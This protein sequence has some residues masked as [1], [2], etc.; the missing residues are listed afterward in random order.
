MAEL[1][2]E[3]LGG[4]RVAVGARAISE[5]AWRR[6]KPAALLKLLALAPGHRLHRVQIMEMLWPELDPPAAGA[7]LRKA[8]H[9]ARRVLSAEEGASLIASVGELLSLRSQRLW[10]D[11]DAF[12][13]A[14]A[15]ARRTRDA[16][17]YAHAI[18][19]YRDGLLP[20]DPYEEW[21]I[22]PRDEFHL[23]FLAIL[24]ELA[25]LLE[26]RGDLDEATR[27][28][29]RLV[30]AEP[31]REE[32]HAWLIRLHALAGRR[33]E[34]L[35]QYE[36][37]RELW[38]DELGSEPS[39]ETQRLYE[40]VRGRQ[41]FEPELTSDLWE[42]VGDLRVLSGDAAGAAKAFGLAL[43][44]AG[45]SDAA[46]RLQRKS[47]GAWLMQHRPDEAE[48]H[49]EAAEELASDPAERGRLVC[50]RANQ[51]WERGDLASAQRLAE[52]ARDLAQAYGD[53]DDV[54][55]A[56]EALAIVLHF[57]G[58]W[59]QGLQLELER[60]AVDESGSAHLGRVF[61]IH[62]CIGQYHLYGD[63]LA[64]D[65]EK[66]ARRTLA[67][68]EEAGAVHAQA[69]AWCLLGES[70][71]LHAR[72]DEVAGC[73]E[74]SC[75]LH[76]SL[77]TYS[78]ALP[79]QRLGELAVCRGAHDEVDKCLRRA[80]ALAT[81]S[82]MAGHLWGRI[83]A[84]AAFAAVEQGDPEAAA[85]SVRAAAGAAARY[86][87]CPT[88][89]ALLNPIAAETFALLGDGD[90]VR[91][92]SRLCT[93]LTSSTAPPGAQWRILRRGAPLPR[94]A[95]GTREEARWRRSTQPARG[96]QMPAPRTRSSR[97]GLSSRL[98]RAGCR[99]PA[100]CGSR[101]TCATRSGSSA[102][103]RSRTSRRY[104]PGRVRLS[105]ASGWLGCCSTWMSSRRPSLPWS[106]LPLQERPRSQWGR[107]P[108][109]NRRMRFSGAWV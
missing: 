55:A 37:L 7:N 93:S 17:A 49:L 2:I 51:A 56:C 26:A 6:R 34:A 104:G 85:R 88:C 18:D 62:C 68:A 106:P 80:S 21:A 102:S 8:L 40:E 25:A 79:W 64:D 76:A 73:L 31:L 4:F 54:A 39:P 86:G 69:F 87:D 13:A 11:V 78:G 10:V 109:P 24:E 53:P 75:E 63:E 94:T 84:T 101:A 77:G 105:S 81:V 57:R 65:V 72:W 60:L 33:G 70:L 82:P 43:E 12:R 92:P 35:R 58:D 67:L 74:R 29:R 27:I 97:H 66:Y 71:L 30:A 22:E 32:S 44:A 61:D 100:R 28:V 23:E 38:S 52:Q 36:H 16:D 15:A 41:A 83:H 14:V 108:A 3:L 89:S 1:R 5:G 46:V 45:S 50:L 42:R 95:A 107:G 91:T 99:V 19:L 48:P 98:G 96:S 90:G 9:Q 47:A 20:E 59:R 103:G